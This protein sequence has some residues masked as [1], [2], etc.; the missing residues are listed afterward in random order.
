MI[1]AV[2][3]RI[4]QSYLVEPFIVQNGEKRFEEVHFIC[5]NNDNNNEIF[6][7]HNY[8]YNDESSN[9]AKYI[10]LITLFIGQI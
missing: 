10:P 3:K 2:S 6:N 1:E 9:F 8:T 4:I 5:K 7:N